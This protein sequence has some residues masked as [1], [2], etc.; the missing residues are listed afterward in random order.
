MTTPVG[1]PRDPVKHA[2]IDQAAD[3]A[4]TQAAK[5]SKPSSAATVKPV[6]IQLNENFFEHYGKHDW[7]REF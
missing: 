5:G 1:T 3:P 4:N 2:D 7:M 6:V